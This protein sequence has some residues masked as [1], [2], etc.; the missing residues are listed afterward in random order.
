MTE[1]DPYLVLGVGRTAEHGAIKAAYRLK[2]RGAHPDRGGDP[3]EFISIVKAFGLLNLIRFR[4]GLGALDGLL[5]RLSRRFRLSIRP[6]ILDDG[7][8]AI[9]VDNARTQAIAQDLLLARKAAARQPE[10]AAL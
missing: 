3:Q 9:D 7:A 5:A 2:V 6:V 4:L 1:F 10:A 8:T